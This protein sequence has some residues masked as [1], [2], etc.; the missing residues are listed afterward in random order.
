MVQRRL[1]QYWIQSLPDSIPEDA[2]DYCPEAAQSQQPERSPVKRAQYHKVLQDNNFVLPYHAPRDTPPIIIEGEEGMHQTPQRVLQGSKLV[3]DILGEGGHA[4]R[5][6]KYSFDSK[7][8]APLKERNS[9]LFL[10][11]PVHIESL[12]L[13]SKLPEDVRDLYRRIQSA[14]VY[15]EAILPPEMREEINKILG[16]EAREVSFRKPLAS[17][18]EPGGA[19]AA[20]WLL[21]IQICEVFE[22]AGIADLQKRHECGWNSHIHGAVLKLVFTSLLSRAG[23]RPQKSRR[24]VARYEAVQTATITKDSAPHWKQ[25]GPAVTVSSTEQSAY[26]SSEYYEELEPNP[27][28]SRTNKVDYVVVLRNVDDEPLQQAIRRVAF[29]NETGTGYVNQTAYN[30][31]F[32]TPIAVSIAT[33]EA[34]SN[35]DP[36][37]QLSLWVAAWHK[38]MYALRQRSSPIASR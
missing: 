14:A 23:F 20:A 37:V 30:P 35:D 29:N 7:P 32:D 2:S 24:V 31:I 28:R 11:K 38:R 34:S 36:M 5:K 8:I 16:D 26:D 27:D 9:L 6:P 18:D 1:V 15:K 13:A 19:K 21:H 12:N 22:A 17:A 3:D 25:G 10:E 4:Q 33:R